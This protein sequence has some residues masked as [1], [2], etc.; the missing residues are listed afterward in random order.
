MAFKTKTLYGLC[1][2]QKY[3]RALLYIRNRSDGGGSYM[4]CKQSTKAGVVGVFL[5]SEVLSNLHKS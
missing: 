3:Q 4:M 5:T 1:E 2:G